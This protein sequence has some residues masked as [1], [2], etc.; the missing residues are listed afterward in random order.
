MPL[1]GIEEVYNFTGK[2][3]NAMMYVGAKP[4]VDVSPG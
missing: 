2:S 4:G 3:L 1:A